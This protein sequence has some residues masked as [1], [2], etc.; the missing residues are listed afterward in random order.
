[1]VGTALGAPVQRLAESG[2][3]HVHALIQRLLMAE[4][5]AVV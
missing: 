1:M 2:F 3:K 4:L 5:I